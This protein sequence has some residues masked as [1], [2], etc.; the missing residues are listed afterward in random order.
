VFPLNILSAETTKG[1]SEST[2]IT[3]YFINRH[4]EGDGGQFLSA[5]IHKGLAILAL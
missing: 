2:L 5:Q 3:S 4:D 1:G